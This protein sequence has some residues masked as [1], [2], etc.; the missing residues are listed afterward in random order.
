MSRRRPQ[1]FTLIEVLISVFIL[2]IVSALC[3]QTLDYV[4]RSRERSDATFG[5]LRAIE[6]TVRTLESDFEQ[7]EPRPVRDVVGTSVLPALLADPRTTTLVSLTHGGWSNSAGLPR[8][9]LQR[10]TYRLESGVLYRDHLTV[11][12]AT[13]AN[14]PV[15]RELLRDVTAVKFRYMDA[16]RAWQN[17]WP[18]SGASGTSM[19]VVPRPGGTGPVGVSPQG[20]LSQRPLAVEITLELKDLGT[21]TRL[22]EV[23]G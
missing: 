6:L 13:L 15:Q 18:A 7:L 12:D 4:R 9:T 10:V 3:Y 17:D 5:R 1:G 2:A 20:A 11:L 16:S 22:V 19:P 8:G 23:P 21:I 14:T